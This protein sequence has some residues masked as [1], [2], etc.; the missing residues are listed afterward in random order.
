MYNKGAILISLVLD[1]FQHSLFILRRMNLDYYSHSMS[2]L[3]HG[4]LLSF[5]LNLSRLSRLSHNNTFFPSQFV[6]RTLK[7]SQGEITKVVF[8]FGAKK[9]KTRSVERTFFFNRIFFNWDR[10]SSCLHQ[11]SHTLELSG[12]RRLLFWSWVT[13]TVH[14]LGH[15]G[16]ALG[17]WDRAWLCFEETRWYDMTNN[18][19][20][21]ALSNWPS[22]FYFQNTKQLWL[23]PLSKIPI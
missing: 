15:I 8:Y 1:S 13:D 10:A 19:W 18:N 11:Y 9:V 12:S 4:E 6:N 5:V 21:V 2:K 20:V 16:I 7:W 3:G 17:H 22:R 14:C 23:T